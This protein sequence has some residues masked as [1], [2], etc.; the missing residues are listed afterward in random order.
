MMRGHVARDRLGAALAVVLVAACST[1]STT[2]PSPTTP[3]QASSATTDST[4][5]VHGTEVC[6]IVDAVYEGNTD[7]ER[8]HC[9]EVTSDARL[10]GEW[11]TWI[12]TEETGGGL[13]AWTGNLVMTNAGGT[14]QGA[15][16][17]TTTGMPTNPMNLGQIV[18]VGE[19][20]Y[21]GLT[22]HEFVSG[23]NGRL[24]SAG[25]IEPS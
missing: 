4:V 19:A 1:G 5:A 23:S 8:F 7:R 21:A 6:R 24:V 25:W 20:G 16:S 15:A 2:R 10:N 11:E 18:W 12:V 13:G 17:G 9:Q 22:Y 3:A 14:W